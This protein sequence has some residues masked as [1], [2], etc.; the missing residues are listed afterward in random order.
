MQSIKVVAQYVCEVEGV[1]CIPGK[2]LNLRDSGE[3][4]SVLHVHIDLGRRETINLWS[5][6]MRGHK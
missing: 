3:M 6:E 4:G 5:F 2:K 1:N